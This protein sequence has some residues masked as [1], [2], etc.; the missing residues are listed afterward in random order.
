M[1]SNEHG[2]QPQ[3]LANWLC[4]FGFVWQGWQTQTPQTHGW[5]LELKVQAITAS[6]GAT[7]KQRGEVERTPR[8]QFRLAG[9]SNIFRQKIENNA[10]T[11]EQ[12]KGAQ[13]DPHPYSDHCS[14]GH[15][16]R[17]LGV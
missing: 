6:S 17:S 2:L 11:H 4:R 8:G 5:P 15:S 3:N 14:T 12:Y 16:M 10:S 13:Q 1:G 9:P 7:K